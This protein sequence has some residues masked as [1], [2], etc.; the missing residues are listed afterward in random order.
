MAR[1]CVFDGARN[2]FD[3]LMEAKDFFDVLAASGQKAMLLRYAAGEV[4][5]VFES[6][7]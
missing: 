1:Y 2:W 7:F 6:T 3:F 4:A 5:E